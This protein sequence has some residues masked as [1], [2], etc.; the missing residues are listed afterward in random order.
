MND[1]VVQ[2]NAESTLIILTNQSRPCMFGNLFTEVELGLHLLPQLSNTNF[3]M[4]AFSSS[5]VFFSR[6]MWFSL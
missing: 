3:S 5:F 6:D 4:V 2:V 1:C